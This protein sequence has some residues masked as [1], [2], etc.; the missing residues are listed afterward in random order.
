[1]KQLLAREQLH[2][3]VLPTKTF[4]YIILDLCPLHGPLV[5]KPHNH[6]FTRK[7]K[8]ATQSLEN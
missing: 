1:M 5:Q 2:Y 7:L 6:Y 8:E 4:L 3:T